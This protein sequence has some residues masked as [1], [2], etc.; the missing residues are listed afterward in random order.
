MN[1]EQIQQKALFFNSL[2]DNEDA[3]FEY[4][5]NEK[6]NLTEVIQQYQPVKEFKPVNTLRFLIA[7]QLQKG[8]VINANDVEKLKEALEARDVSAYYELNNEVKQSLGNY[9]DGKT[10]MFPNWKHNFKVLFPFLYN[11]ADDQEVTECLEKLADEIIEYNNLERVTKHIV[12]FNGPQNYGADMVWLAIIP[13]TSPSVQYAYQIFFSI[14]SKGMGG[15]IHKGHNLTK[16]VYDNQ[17]VRFESWNEYL[18]Y[19]SSIKE[20]WTSLNSEVNFLLLTD[21]KDFIKRIKKIKVDVLGAFFRSL[22]HLVEDLK[23]ENEED[24]VFSVASGQLSFQIGKRF[25]LLVKNNKFD[26]ITSN[27]HEISGLN[28]DVFSSPDN[29]FLYRGASKLQL[30]E[31]YNV[32]RDAV[33]SE[34][35]RDN[36]I[37]PKDYDNSAFR[38]A[39]FDK[40]YRN[41]ILNNNGLNV[42]YYV[43]G[44]Y[45]GNDEP[46]DQTERFVNEGIWTNGYDDKFLKEVNAVEV[47]SRIAIKSAYTREKTR[48]VMAIKAIGV[49]TQN[50]N[51]G[52]NLKVDWDKTFEPFEVDF[53][54]Y[55]N[56]IKQV[57]QENHI[58]AIW[59]KNMNSIR[60]EF[61]NWLNVKESS[62]KA[63][64]YI[65]AIDILNELLNKD[66]YAIDN[67]TEL[68]TLYEDLVINQRLDDSKYFYAKAPS[69]GRN[70][71]YSASIKAFIQFLN[72]RD[73]QVTKPL[74][75]MKNSQPPKNQIY[76]GPPGTGKT[77]NTINNALQ[78]LGEDIDNLT[79]S[80]VKALFKKRVEE[81]RIVFT[82]FHQSMSYEDFIEG[83]KPESKEEAIS[84]VIQDGIFKQL[85]YKALFAHY[86][87]SSGIVEEFNEFDNLYDNYVASVESRL[88]ALKE[89]EQLLL[90]LKTSGFFTEI[91]A[92]NEDENYLLTRGAK[93]NSD[94]KVF[95]EKLRP[96]YNK[97]KSIDDIKDVRSVGKGLGWSSNY[98]GVFKDLKSFEASQNQS[99]VITEGP[100]ISYNDYDKIKNIILNSNHPV[101]YNDEA[102]R[103]VL[104]IDEINRGSVSQIFGELITLLESDKRLG[105]DEEL[106]LVLPYSKTAFGVPP[107]LF[108]LGTM[109]TADRSVEALDTALRRRFSFIEMPPKPELIK[110][111]GK[112][113]GGIVNN[114]ELNRLLNTLNIRIEKLLDKD[115]MIG[116]SYFMSVSNLSELKSAFQNKIIPLLQEYFFGDYGKIGLILGT[117]FF[118]IKENN[119]DETFFAAFDDYDSSPLLERR[120]YH[121][122][123]VQNMEDVEFLEALKTLERKN[124]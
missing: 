119:D 84:Y 68:N 47:G 77:Y 100:S 65:R 87:N 62:N 17:D 121:L 42:K 64:S 102:D 98:Y 70:G 10:G 39:V 82:T 66:I 118:D 56:T 73:T 81:G 96:L 101:N 88:E 2:S 20:E 108:V 4:I 7:N 51:D 21:E 99:P 53:G 97:F 79:R 35:E 94:A 75:T 95:K 72:E 80:E 30:E 58:K 46:K 49:V 31:N 74:K 52:R 24:L 76:Y 124:Q 36:N 89:D 109:N 92:I 34:L 61:K 43:V 22:D 18:A 117:G 63:D 12:G 110:T 26:F 32:I 105:C 83:I 114:I 67:I 91:K 9:K 11:A 44:A 107:N 104:I 103:F 14:D 106:S 60:E 29:A 37:E 116:H 86:S 57:K 8:E 15:G 111:H 6:P 54:G 113:Q 23:I 45:W 33:E 122:K 1:L 27:T 112:A 93:A 90:P 85:C 41:K 78:V 50:L 25:C 40:E 5:N 71:F 48:S 59:F 123:D 28:K 38:K 120:V 69:Y 19:T 3:L 13:E 16:R 55:M 115:H